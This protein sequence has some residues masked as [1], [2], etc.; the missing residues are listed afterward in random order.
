MPPEEV[1]PGRNFM[2]WLRWAA[3][4]FRPR[5]SSSPRHYRPS[6]ELL[7]ERC[8]LSGADMAGSGNSNPTPAAVG[9]VSAPVVAVTP[10]PA[11]VVGHQPSFG[12]L[13]QR[14]DHVVQF[15]LS[16]GRGLA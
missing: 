14:E 2:T 7:E 8:A 1:S 10:A 11:P 3:P 12:S 15:T 9:G 13:K 5:Q 6:L 4:F 16:Y